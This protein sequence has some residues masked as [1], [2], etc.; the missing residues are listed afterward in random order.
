MN[1]QQIVR[2]A[3]KT[4]KRCDLHKV[5]NGPVPWSG[6]T[7]A[8]LVVIGEAP[9]RAEDTQGKPFVGP[10]GKLLRRWLEEAGLGDI[11]IAY[12]NVVSCWPDGTPG[13]SHL[14]ACHGNLVI[15]L[16]VIRA[17]YALVVGATALNTLLPWN[18]RVGELRGKWWQP[19]PGL[20]AINTWHPA[21]ILRSP[22]TSMDGEVIADL[23]TLATSVLFGELSRPQPYSGCLRC[24]KLS[25][26]YDHEIGFCTK[27]D[28]TGAKSQV[29]QVAL[30]GMGP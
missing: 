6:P 26:V 29:S 1:Q 19:R 11:D 30:P 27:H 24:G 14:R 3:V 9:G 16:D 22:G 2:H 21:A 28:P 5:G 7:P 18:V 10:A 13:Q 17:E 23:R 4:C 8:K 12:V 25:K 15:Q 20:W